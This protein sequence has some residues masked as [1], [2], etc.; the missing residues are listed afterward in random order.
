MTPGKSTHAGFTLIEL[1]VVMAI[2]GLLL[3]I[4]APRFLGSIENG[5]RTVQRQNVA[6]MRDAIDKFRGD[7]GRY[8]E[9]LQELVDKR[10]LREVPVDPV[11][12]TREWRI[13]APSD[14]DH[15]VYDIAPPVLPGEG[16]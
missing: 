7:L 14:V 15:G 9:S 12:E 3:S 2:I 1:V 13:T 4:A 16:R 10:Y 6:V 5:K 8:P 11:T